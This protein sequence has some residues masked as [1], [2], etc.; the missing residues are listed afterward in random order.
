MKNNWSN[1]YDPLTMYVCRTF[2]LFT[3]LTF[4]ISFLNEDLFYVL[5]QHD[6]QI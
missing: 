3:E 4:K 6:F 2:F 5:L 1:S